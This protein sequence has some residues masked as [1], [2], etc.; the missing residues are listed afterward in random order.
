MSYD[1]DIALRTW[2][3]RPLADILASIGVEARLDGAFDVDRNV[4]VTRIGASERTID[5]DGPVQVEPDDLEPEIGAVLPMELAEDAFREMW[6]GRT[7]GKTVFT[8]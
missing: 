7:R 2:P 3:G 5:L 6:G 8:R 4:L 1:L